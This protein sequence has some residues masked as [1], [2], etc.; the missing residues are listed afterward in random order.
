MIRRML[1]KNQKLYDTESESE[2]EAVNQQL[3]LVA[4]ERSKSRQS[5]SKFP[6]DLL[7][8]R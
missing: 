4:E 3:L 5:S 8:G 1:N 6:L 7:F 2:E